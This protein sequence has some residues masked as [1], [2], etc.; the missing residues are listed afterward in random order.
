[1][2]EKGWCVCVR[3]L[4]VEFQS[5][6]LQWK[7]QY[8]MQ[9][10]RV[11]TLRYARRTPTHVILATICNNWKIMYSPAYSIVYKYSGTLK[12][13]MEHIIYTPPPPCHSSPHTQET[14]CFGQWRP[15]CVL[16]IAASG[17]GL[18]NETGM[19]SLSSGSWAQSWKRGKHHWGWIHFHSR[20]S[21]H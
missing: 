8:C 15:V 18:G 5:V 6:T 14:H 1:M 13:N 7:G 19:H 9:I 11:P 10:L 4:Q 3:S 21:L 17:S 16:H 12:F 2:I 20:G